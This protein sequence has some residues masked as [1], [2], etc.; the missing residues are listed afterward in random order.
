MSYHFSL[1]LVAMSFKIRQKMKS[2]K[3]ILLSLVTTQMLL[4][5]T[6]DD[7]MESYYKSPTPDK[8]IA[9]VR[10]MTNE[11]GLKKGN[12]QPPVVAFLSRLMASNPKE[13][14]KWLGEFTDLDEKQRTVLLAAAWYSDTEEAR[15][16]LRTIN[17]RPT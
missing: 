4:A 16:F 1:P 8:F 10:S 3:L 6:G 5:G 14:S 13:I 9:E 12:A 7:W 2:L 11:G 15:T 17:S